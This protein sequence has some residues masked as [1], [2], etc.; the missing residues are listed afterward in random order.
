MLL[1]KHYDTFRLELERQEYTLSTEQRI[2]L[3]CLQRGFPFTGGMMWKSWT[4][5][6]A[7]G[8]PSL[9]S[10]E[11]DS[12]LAPFVFWAAHDVFVIR[13]RYWTVD[14]DKH[15]ST[16]FLTLT[17]QHLGYRDRRFWDLNYAAKKQ[18][19]AAIESARRAQH[20]YFDNFRIELFCRKC[21]TYGVTLD[22]QNS[23]LVLY[24]ANCGNSE[25]RKT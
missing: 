15:P 11:G 21:S 18:K 19:E 13:Q 14:T 8:G 1:P 10:W 20:A 17:F 6:S 9:W 25:E 22:V 4:S 24:C 5:K 23:Q 3:N 7:P 2:M 12:R 16:P